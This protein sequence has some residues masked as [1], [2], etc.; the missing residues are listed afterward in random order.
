MLA[1][2]TREVAPE[3]LALVCSGA[4]PGLGAGAT[5]LITDV[6]E[7]ALAG[8]HC[9]SFSFFSSSFFS[10]SSSS[11][12]SSSPS[13]P[14]SPLSETSALDGRFAAAVVWPRAHLG[15]DFSLACLARA[16]LLL[17]PGGRLLCAVRKNKGGGSLAREIDR[18]LG[19]LTTLKRDRGYSLYCGEHRGE[20][21]R[22]A[23]SALLGVSYSIDE[24][25][26]GAPP[27]FATP[28]VF[29]RKHLDR[30]TRAL[31]EHAAQL[32]MR[33]ALGEPRRVL[34]LCA[35]IGPLGLWAAR[36]WP[37]AAITA[38]ESNLLAIACLKANAAAR[39]LD[40]PPPRLRIEAADGLAKLSLPSFDLA[41]VN[42]PTHAGEDELR[43]LLAPL[44]GLLRGGLALFVVN[45]EGRLV[46]L[47]EELSAAIELAAVPG[48]SIV[49]ARW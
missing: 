2:A 37:D 16:A 36:R 26:L 28:G 9:F 15:K 44:P 31:I 34:D 14:S 10:S 24:P 41:L 20:I 49:S 4:L 32:A 12:S 7:E 1:E 27:L 47:L 8:E 45:R 18:L 39:G 29:S 33:G 25:L 46:G 40:A 30:G 22:G 35:G 48:F 13:S 11:S 5:R 23:A 17:R 42:P 3:E 43:E 19:N 38:V 6:R 21:D